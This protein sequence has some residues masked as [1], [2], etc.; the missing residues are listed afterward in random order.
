MSAKLLT[1][2]FLECYTIQELQTI[3]VNRASGIHK[4]SFASQMANEL[5][6]L[7]QKKYDHLLMELNNEQMGLS[8]N[9]TNSNELI[10]G[11][12]LFHIN[13]KANSIR[14]MKSFGTKAIF[15]DLYN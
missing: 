7:F 14:A 12:E 2:L 5:L 13:A 1:E 4:D 3:Y 15:R 11:E 6:D 9:A 8:K 10:E